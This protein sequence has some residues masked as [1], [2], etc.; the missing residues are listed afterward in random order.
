MD[1]KMGQGRRT[2][3][4]RMDL[5]RHEG[6]NEIVCYEETT[7][8]FTKQYHELLHF[9]SILLPSISYTVYTISFIGH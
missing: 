1:S 8:T 5:R 9:Y 4:L 3:S 2:F 7:D 6:M